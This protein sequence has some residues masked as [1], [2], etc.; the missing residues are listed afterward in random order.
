MGDIEQEA[1][2]LRTR[3]AIQNATLSAIGIAGIL[4]IGV[5]APNTL[6]LLGSVK[7]K[8]RFF[9][10]STNALTRLKQKGLITFVKKDEVSYAR[11]TPKGQRLLDNITTIPLPKKRWDKRWRMVIFDIP[12]KWR[13]S[14]NRLTALIRQLGFF[15]LQ[16]SVWV[17]PYDS[18]ELIALIK[19]E[20]R[21]GKNVRYV[22][23]EKIEGDA[24]IKAHFGLK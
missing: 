23:A 19:L 16:D 15:R 21:T 17:Y 13:K 7:N 5:M 24:E 4:A 2:K 14:R 1:R 22:I 11:L 8:S 18:E 12:E 10:Q 9:A 6:K 3:G 20:L